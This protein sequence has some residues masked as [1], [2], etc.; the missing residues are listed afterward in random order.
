MKK[1]AKI[2][3]KNKYVNVHFP[4][5]HCVMKNPDKSCVTGTGCYST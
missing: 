5:F 2:C 1:E 3:L 4:G